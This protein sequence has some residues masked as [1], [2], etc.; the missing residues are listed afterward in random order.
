MFTGI[1]TDIGI[2]RHVTKKKGGDLCC[3]IMTAYD[4]LTMNLGMSISCAGVCLTVIEKGKDSNGDWFSVDITQET[5][6]VTTAG[7]GS[8]WPIGTHLN[9][10][11]PLKMGD[12]FG[13]HIVTGHIDAVVDIVD[14]QPA[15]ESICCVFQMIKNLSNFIVPKGSVTLNGTSFTVNDVMNQGFCVNIIPYTQSSTTWKKVFIGE[16]VNLEVD[17]LARY[18]SK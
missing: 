6:H 13:G 15:G 2:V 12:E 14:V 11:R 17:I 16:S 4:S 5:L 10:E 8:G 3:M 1:I 9:L 7:N 18:A